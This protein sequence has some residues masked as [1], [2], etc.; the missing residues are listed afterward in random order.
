MSVVAERVLEM[1]DGTKVRRVSLRILRPVRDR[2]PGG[3]WGCTVQFRGAP[4]GVL[5]R[6][7]TAYGVDTLQALVLAIGCA[8][9]ELTRAQVKTKGRLTWLDGHD[10]GLPNILGLVGIRQM[11][12]AP[13]K[14]RL[15]AKYAS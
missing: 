5:R 7:Q 14:R 4:R 12:R 3:D 1:R 8:Q 10:L 13:P 11:F 6:T 2:R 9:R 15:S